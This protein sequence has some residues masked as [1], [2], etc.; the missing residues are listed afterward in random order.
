MKQ[1]H[2]FISNKEKEITYEVNSIMFLVSS[3]L[4]TKIF[5]VLDH[6]KEITNKNIGNQQQKEYIEKERDKAI[7]IID[8]VT[9]SPEFKPGKIDDPLHLENF[10][11]IDVSSLFEN[12]RET[13]IVVGS[14]RDSQNRQQYRTPKDDYAQAKKFRDNKLTGC[15]IKTRFQ[16]NQ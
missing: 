15:E 6:C 1:L 11:N 14:K 9:D 2:K 3:D 13:V 10:E 8:K 4:T 16:C 7:T 5:K 12:P